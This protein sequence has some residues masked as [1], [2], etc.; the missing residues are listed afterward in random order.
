MSRTLTI[1]VCGLTFFLVLGLYMERAA[2]FRQAK[3]FVQSQSVPTALLNYGTMGRIMKQLGVVRAIPNDYSQFPA[4]KNDQ[5]DLTSNILQKKRQVGE[6]LYKANPGGVKSMPSSIV[7]DEKDFRDH[8]PLISIVADPNNLYGSEGIITNTTRR[9]RQWE[10]LAYVSY[11]ENG[12]LLFSSGAGLRIHGGESRKSKIRPQSFRLYFRKDYGA[13]QFPSGILFGPETEPLKRLVLRIDWLQSWPFICPLAFDVIRQ[14]GGTAPEAKPVSFFLNGE[15]MGIY[16]L[17]E[18]LSKRQWTSHL[19]HDNFV[20]YR[21]KNANDEETLKTYGGMI[22][23]GRDMKMKMTMEEAAKYIDVDSL[24]R[25]I[26]S[27][28][29]CGDSD[30]FQGVAVLDKSLPDAKWFWINWDPDHSFQDRYRYKAKNKKRKIW[31]QDAIELVIN[32]G[33][34]RSVL[35]TRLLTESL[36]YRLYFLR[37]VTDVL[38]HCITAE[39]MNSRIDHYEQLAI[40]YGIQD[41]AFINR[42]RLFTEH[43]P[44]FIRKQMAQYCG[45][46][47][48]FSCEVKGPR[49]IEYNIDGYPER[50]GYQGWY[51][52]GQPIRVEIAGQHTRGFSHWL[53]NGKKVAVSQLVYPVSSAIVIEPVFSE[54]F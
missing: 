4:L 17:S 9:G 39:F 51:F 7:V 23:W 54:R 8:W 36:Q 12:Q 20:F 32:K 6:Y 1:I 53:V 40:S 33:L 22:R 2:P 21:Y 5:A 29:Y 28:M 43:R 26:F 15:P 13:D 30:G 44:A 18:H 52:R 24:S 50:A 3:L 10:R 16:W 45:A 35:F 38:N 11:Y 37:L 19:G 27:I 31:E 49:G 47:E 46:G 25:Y 14:I 41:F 42:Y 34:I 48:S